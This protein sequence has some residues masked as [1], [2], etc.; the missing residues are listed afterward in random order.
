VVCHFRPAH[1]GI[2]L[3]VLPVTAWK[4]SEALW[5][6]YE[7]AYI[8]FS[9]WRWRWGDPPLAFHKLLFPGAGLSCDAKQQHSNNLIFPVLFGDPEKDR[10]E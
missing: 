1:H 3:G 5:K 6:A 9:F 4:C 2:D 10:M 7:N 8:S